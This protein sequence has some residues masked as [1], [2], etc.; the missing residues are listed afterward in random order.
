MVS[1]RAVAE[2]ACNTVASMA[3][4]F[5]DVV[6]DW[7]LPAPGFNFELKAK[8]EELTDLRVDKHE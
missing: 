5:R 8:I 7:D 1:T 4:A 3:L 6:D 2:W